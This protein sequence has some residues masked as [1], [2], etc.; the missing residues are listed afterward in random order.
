MKAAAV[1]L[2]RDG[3]IIDDRGYIADAEDVEVLPGSADAIRR[4][5]DAGYLIVVASNQS[6][7]PGLGFRSSLSRR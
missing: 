5:S 6:S 1:F 4:F 7:I 2:D 3:T